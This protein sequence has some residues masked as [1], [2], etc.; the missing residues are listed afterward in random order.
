M[1][2]EHPKAFFTI[3]HFNGYAAILIELRRARAKDVRAA[4]VDA[5]RTMAER[6]KPKAKAKAARGGRPKS[7]RK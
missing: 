5:H 6:T 7:A 2:A 1:L 3:P 4:I